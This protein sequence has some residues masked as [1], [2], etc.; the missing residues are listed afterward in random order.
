[1][2]KRTVDSTAGFTL[3][4]LLVVMALIGIILLVLFNSVQG[5]TS[6]ATQTN[7]RSELQQ[8]L[9][10]A[11]RIVAS[12]VQEALYVYPEGQKFDFGSSPL[13]KNPLDN[14]GTWITGTSPILAMIL[15]PEK[16][17]ILCGAGANNKGCYRFF[18]YYPVKRSG[19]VGG[20]TNSNNPGADA[21]ND[22]SVWV[23]AEY[24]DFY[25]GKPTFGTN[26]FAAY[27][28][29]DSSTKAYILA[30]YITP[31][32][33]TAAPNAVYT[34][35]EY[36]IPNPLSIIPGACACRRP[37]L[38]QS[39]GSM[40][41][42]PLLGRQS[43]RLRRDYQSGHPAQSGQQPDTLAGR[44]GHLYAGRRAAEHRGVARHLAV[45]SA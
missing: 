25:A 39:G 44:H 33:T 34:M 40:H 19:W 9:L 14:S 21:A 12:R 17:E 23:L 29:P 26:G 41:A 18:A 5:T 4:E 32:G 35:F 10:N 16:S 31:T 27:P 43:L 45:A 20:T 36:S 3:V 11:Q 8:E 38:A 22:S 1:M 24:R 13:R 7:T 6:A 2:K 28:T 37:W 42:C 15:P 30:D